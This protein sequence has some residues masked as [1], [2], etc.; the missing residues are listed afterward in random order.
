MILF[1]R[2]RND[3]CFGFDRQKIKNK[4]E[5]EDDDDENIKKIEF[6]I[7]T[8]TKEERLAHRNVRLSHLWLDSTRHRLS[9]RLPLVR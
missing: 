3:I 8:L 5:E 1:Q 9:S 7:E 2:K 6:F 4:K